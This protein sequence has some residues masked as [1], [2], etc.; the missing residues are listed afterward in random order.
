[1]TAKSVKDVR[2][3]INGMSIGQPISTREAFALLMTILN[4]EMQFMSVDNIKVWI[5]SSIELIQ[6]LI[7]DNKDYHLKIK[8]NTMLE[9]IE[10]ITKHPRIMQFVTDSILSFEGYGNLIGFNQK[11]SLVNPE[12]GLLK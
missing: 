6:E 10:N 12:R 1:M 5:R 7:K 9:S 8:L 11:E 3:K 4:D 2:V